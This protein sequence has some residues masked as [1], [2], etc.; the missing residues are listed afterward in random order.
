MS[1]THRRVPHKRSLRH[2]AHIN[3]ERA[4]EAACEEMADAGFTPTNRQR[5]SGT[6][7]INAYDDQFISA[8]DQ[9]HNTN[10]NAKDS[11]SR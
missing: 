5:S 8:L 4:E 1:D 6:R 7:I 11:S 9:K 10:N 3:Y 2:P